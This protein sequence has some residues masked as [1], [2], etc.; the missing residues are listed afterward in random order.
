MGFLPWREPGLPVL[1]AT[2]LPFTL[3][4]LNGHLC[5]AGELSKGRGGCGRE[6]VQ[7]RGGSRKRA[8]REE[9]GAGGERKSW[10]RRDFP[11]IQPSLQP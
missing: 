1:T 11:A 7:I 9:D 4:L 8:W 5:K 10:Q 2:A 3:Q 6:R